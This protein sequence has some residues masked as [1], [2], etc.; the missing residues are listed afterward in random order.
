MTLDAMRHEMGQI[1]REIA[2]RQQIAGK[3]AR[4]KHMEG[5]PIRDDAQ[6]REVLNRAFDWAVEQKIDPVSVQNI[7]EVLVA[8]SEERQ[9][10]C[11]GD[12]NLP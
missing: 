3:I 2:R 4:V 9:R 10:E 5:F 8:M 7:F 11:L 6:A 1:D 12:G